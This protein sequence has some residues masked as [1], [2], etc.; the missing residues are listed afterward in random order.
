LSLL[1][2]KEAEEVTELVAGKHKLP[3]LDL[4]AFPIDT[5]AI[6]VIPEERARAGELAVFQAAGSRLKIAVRDPDKSETASVLKDLESRRFSYELYLVSRQSLDR[7][8]TI[9]GKVPAGYQASAGTIAILPSKLSAIR[10]EII[11]LQD[12]ARQIEQRFFTNTSEALE[13][14]LAGALATEA[15]D[16]HIEPQEKAVRLRLRLDGILHDISQLPPKLHTLL[17][18]RIKLI[19]ELKLNIHDRA[20]D[21]RFTIQMDHAAIEVRTSVLPG[22]NGENIVLRILNPRSIE[23]SFTDLGLQPWVALMIEKELRQPNGLILTTGPTGSGKTTTLY[24]FLR[25][26]HNP[27]IK[28]VTIEDPIEYHLTG[29]EQ[30]QADPDKGY[31]FAEGLRAIVRQDPDV[32]LVGEIRDLDTAETAMHAALTGHLVFSTLHTNDAAGTIPRLVDLGVKP[33]IIAPAINVAMAQRL[34][35]KL[36]PACRQNVKISNPV[37]AGIKKG[38]ALFPSGVSLPREKEWTLFQPCGTGCQSCNGI[39]YKGRTGI[40]EIIFVDDRM[41]RLILSVAPESEI[42]KA[43]LDSGQ[44]TMRQDGLLKVLHGIT[45]FAELERVVGE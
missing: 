16:V 18:S 10:Q 36:C 13:V 34:V 21:G 35:R 30:T 32:I 27:A 38:L 7:A 12:V 25:A 41:E 3:Y 45:D 40:Y 43:A 1:R 20:Q 42:K 44:I 37:L 8:W 4:A 39:G 6:K 5:D 29:I 15:S 24:T 9:Y 22:P 19:S 2:R 26:I 17:L 28:I 23:L 33:S 14:I 31:G 11:S